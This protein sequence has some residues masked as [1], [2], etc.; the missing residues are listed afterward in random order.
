MALNPFFL[1]GSKS[2]QNLVQQLIN[3]QLRMYGVEIIYM[4]RRY[5]N[6][7]TVIKENVLSKFDENYAIEAYVKNYQGFGGGGDILTKFGIQSKDEL[8]LVISR[9]RFETFISPFLIDGEGNLRE[10]YKIAIRPAEGD[11]IYF[12]LSDTI[13][14]IKFIEHEVEFYQL[15]KLYVYELVCEP[16]EY[17]DE[18]IDTDIEEIDDNFAERGYA[19]KLTLVGIGSTATAVTSLRTG[20]VSTITLMNDGYGYSSTPSVA[21]QASPAG[22][23]NATAVAIM[24]DRSSAG[25]LTALAI[26]DVLITNPG[27]GYTTAPTI[28]FI[29]G[30]GSGAIATAGITTSGSIGIVTVSYGGDKYVVTP[31]ITFTNAPSGGTTATGVAIVSAAGTISQIRIINA[32]FGY[33]VTP[34]ITIESPSG[35]GTGNFVLNEIVTGAASSTAGYVKTWDADTLILKVNNVTGTFRVGEII[36]GSATTF[37]HV[38]LGT[39]GRY[40]IKSIEKMSDVNSDDFEDF[41]QNKEIEDAADLILDFSEK[42]PFG[43]Y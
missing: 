19:V 36:V 7:K 6:E 23:I 42:H 33:T 29:G 22:G 1:Q 27:S 39:T 17:E 10:D 28:R 2:E 9:E 24:T 13:F 4:P 38:G 21:I 20:T 18:I 15:Q 8:N 31:S 12:P 11:L 3:E 26:K 30:G 16:F 40:M 41:M 32:G 34:T 35:V 5:L 14:E 43:N 37:S 25:I